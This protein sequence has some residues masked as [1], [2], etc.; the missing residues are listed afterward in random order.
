METALVGHQASLKKGNLQSS[1]MFWITVKFLRY[2]SH[3][4]IFCSECLDNLALPILPSSFTCNIPSYCSGVECCISSSVLG[5]S[6]HT[7]LEID[8]CTSKIVV[9]ID[10]WKFEEISL[11]TDKLLSTC[12]YSISKICMSMLN[13]TMPMKNCLVANVSYIFNL[14]FFSSLSHDKKCMV[15]RSCTH[16]VSSRF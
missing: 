7:Y 5:R 4:M 13:F 1:Q 14:I 9:G 8:P 16:G 15:T 10:K 3:V 2:V 12:M 11:E 6:F